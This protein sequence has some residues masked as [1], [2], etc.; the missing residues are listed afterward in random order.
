MS[1]RNVTPGLRMSERELQDAVA[2]MAGALG[3]RVF[4][5]QPARTNTGWRT[6]VAYDGAGFVDLLLV[7]DRVLFAELKVGRNRP[8][9]AQASWLEALTAA[10]AAAHVWTDS[11]WVAR[12]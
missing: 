5:T 3:W 8:S 1:R 11:D 2:G 12:S 9:A 6:P 4:H 10:G 7:R